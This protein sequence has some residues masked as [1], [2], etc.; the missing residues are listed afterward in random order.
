MNLTSKALFVSLGIAYVPSLTSCNNQ[1]KQRPNILIIFTDDQGYNDLECFGSTVH[2]TPVLNELAQQG[3]SFSNFYAQPVSGASRSALMTGR[4]PYRS[5]GRDMPTE[6]F[7]LA[8]MAKEMGYQTVCIGKWDLTTK[9][10]PIIEQMA[11][12]QGFDYYYGA[13]GA[14]DGAVIKL[15]ENNDYLGLDRDMS[16]LIRRY[17]DK[18]IE[19]LRDKRNKEQPFLL[20]L[21]H[22]M[23]HV[24]IDASPEF[25]GKSK[26]GLYGDVVEEFDYHTGRLLDTL[27]ELD[28][29][30]NTIIIYA[31]DNG[32]WCQQKYIDYRRKQT[33]ALEDVIFWGDSGVLRAGKGSAYEG[34]SKVRAIMKWGDKIPAGRDC[35]GLMATIDIM[36]TMASWMGY[37]LCDDIRMDGVNQSDMIL[38]K[39]DESRRE[40]FCYMQHNF[41]DRFVAI[42]DSRWKLLLPHRRINTV[43]LMDFGTD[44]YELYDLQ[45]DISES[46]NLVEQHPEIVE[47]LKLEL[48]KNL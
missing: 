47:R 9:R 29:E 25:K 48:E 27:K 7:T 44:D 23:M 31:T 19:F 11:N 33:P 34:G 2:K 30:D 43:Y 8:E 24:Q 40:T 45:N 3:T 16:S 21:S 12:A 13:L 18:S 46:V 39:S 10:Q 22:T 42:R 41:Y 14:N 35:N 1:E 20:Y 36:P 5:L 15:F 17:T 32:A 28:L 38:G 6:E 26:G 4:Y 37:T